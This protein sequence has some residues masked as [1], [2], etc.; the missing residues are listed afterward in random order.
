MR[1]RGCNPKYFKSFKVS[2]RTGLETLAAA[3]R[4][5]TSN[6]QSDQTQAGKFY[7]FLN[8]GTFHL[9]IS[10]QQKGALQDMRTARQV[11]ISRGP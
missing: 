5:A 1:I 4:Y 10:I 7:L 8:A 6:W 3:A 11:V 9:L 2:G